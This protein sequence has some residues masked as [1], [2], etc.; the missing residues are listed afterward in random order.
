MQQTG[1]VL[2]AF[3]TLDI[4]PQTLKRAYAKLVWAYLSFNFVNRHDLSDSL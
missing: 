3:S 1:K 2:F 4:S